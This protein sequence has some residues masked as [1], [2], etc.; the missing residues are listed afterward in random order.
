MD[1][2]LTF[3]T[4][5]HPQNDG[6]TKRVNQILEDMLRACTI[7]YGKIWETCLPFAG[8]SYN[9]S[10]QTSIGMSPFEALYGRSCRT[11][12]NWSDSGERRYFGLDIVIEAEEKVKMIQERLETTQLRQKHYVDQRRQQIEYKVGD[13][14]YLKVSPF[15]GTKRFEEKGKL[16]PRC[17]GPFRI[18]AR[19]GA[20]AYQLELPQSLSSLHDVFH[21][22][23]LKKCFKETNPNDRGVNIDDINL[24]PILSCKEYPIRI[25]DRAQRKTRNKATKFVKVQWS[26]HSVWEATWEQDD[27]LR[28]DYPSLFEDE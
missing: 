5:Y 19:C 26:C 23:Q 10:F 1:T 4:A 14:V 8:F 15:K 9:N 6:Q 2:T 12:L 24:Q 13:H 7:I 25:L 22:S 27:Q 18:V 28:K 11:P 21:V 20:V 3:G 16:A 17:V